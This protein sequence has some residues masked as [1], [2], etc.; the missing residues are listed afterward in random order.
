[1]LTRGRSLTISLAVAA[2]IVAN[3]VSPQIALA[4]HHGPASNVHAGV[5]LASQD[6]AAHDHAATHEKQDGGSANEDNGTNTPSKFCCSTMTCT[7]GAI[8]TSAPAT[9][10][11][12][13]AAR[14][15]SASFD[16]AP[17]AFD[18]SAIDPPPRV[19]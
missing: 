13:V 5:H 11:H 4:A 19:G 3:C 15:V 10:L 12:R 6:H 7:A 14:T 8:L 9:A 1:M 2:M 16:E 17:R 18:N